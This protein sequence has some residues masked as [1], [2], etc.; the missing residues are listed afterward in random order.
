MMVDYS[1]TKITSLRNLSFLRKKTYVT[2]VETG[3][4]LAAEYSLRVEPDAPVPAHEPLDEMGWIDDVGD[5]V[6]EDP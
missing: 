1:S 6:R 4:D 3:Q 5:F 2:H